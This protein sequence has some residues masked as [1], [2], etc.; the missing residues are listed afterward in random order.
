MASAQMSQLQGPIPEISDREPMD[1]DTWEEQL[2]R[3]TQTRAS[4]GTIEFLVDGD[5]YF[6]RLEAAID[7]ATESIDIR[8]YIFDND[9]YAISIADLLKRKSVD[10]DVH[11]ILPA[12][13]NHDMLDLSNAIAINHMLAHGIRV[14]RYPGMS[15]TKAA[16]FDG[17][18][19]VGSANFDKLSLEVNKELNLAASDPGVARAL[20]EPLFLPDQ[21]Q[22]EEITS[23]IDTTL[24]ARLA[25]VVVDELL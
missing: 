1:L 6:P 19:C 12:D 2:D 16:I 20:L 7:G 9:D 8:T 5:E 25:E 3:I 14:Y 23:Q 18:V 17:W 13:G 15:H 11:V 22:S 21:R 4:V 10:V 24:R